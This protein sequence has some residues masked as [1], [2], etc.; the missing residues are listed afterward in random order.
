MRDDA[1]L[2]T[3]MTSASRKVQEKKGEKSQQKTEKRTQL[4]PYTEIIVNEIQKDKDMLGELLLGI[5]NPDTPDDQLQAK[6]DAIRLHRTWLLS[7]E[8]RMKNILRRR[9]KNV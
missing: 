8:T 6:L 2:Y 9:E 7:F 1:L 4:E 5:V 3:G